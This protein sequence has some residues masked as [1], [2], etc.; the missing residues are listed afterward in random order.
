MKLLL[1]ASAVVSSIVLA[2]PALEGEVEAIKRAHEA[3]K[4][5]VKNFSNTLQ[6]ALGKKGAAKAIADCK[7]H[8]T[9]AGE[10]FTVG[11]TSH[12]L[13][14]PKNAPPDWVKPH[15]EKFAK[16][17]PSDIPKKHLVNRGKNG[18]GYLEPIFVEPICL[19]CHG[20][21]VADDTNQA[22]RA[23]Y[24]TDQATGF[25]VGDF[26]GLLWVEM[27][28]TKTKA[29]SRSTDYE[30]LSILTK[31]CA[32]C[33]QSADHPGAL[34]LNRERLEEKETLTLVIHMLESSQMPPQHRK[35]KKSQDGKRLLQWLKAKLAAAES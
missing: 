18:Y 3:S 2:D 17:K 27:D 35:F 15:L 13:R 16:M 24:P 29:P 22:I 30:P 9:D 31:H 34:F 21:N 6:Q 8:P 14:N 4:T 5:V 20:K 7:I 33:H 1:L 19:N 32:G 10:V 28:P 23:A 26:R 11:R 25:E 12:R